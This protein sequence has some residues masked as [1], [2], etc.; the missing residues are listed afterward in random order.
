MVKTV[1]ELAAYAAIT[2]S[3]TTQISETQGTNWARDVVLFGQAL[4]QFDQS[5]IVD[6]SIVNTNDKTAVITKETGTL[7]L[8]LSPSGGE[9]DVADFTELT[10]LDTVSV[11]VANSNHLRGEVAIGKYIS[12][13]SKIDL[14]KQGRY[15]IAE[16]MAQKIDTDLA[17]ATQDTTVDNRVFGDST[18]TDPSGLGA[19]DVM[20]PDLIADGKSEIQANNF[21][22]KWLYVAPQQIKALVKDP[23]FTNAA[24]FGSDSVIARGE[25]TN[26]LGV[27]IVAT[28]N[29]PAFASSASD[30]NQGP[31]YAWGAT[32]H[33]CPMIGVSKRGGQPVAHALVW[34]QQPQV[35]YEYDRRR[36]LHRL[37]FDML[38]NTAMIQP[39]AVCLIKVSDA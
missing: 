24:E 34:K 6:T 19:T 4:R 18:A 9:S 35:D 30:T 28:T 37:Y 20:T 31:T 27:N 3:S 22:P 39:E 33:S 17:A 13:T 25:I 23:Q 10:N 1:E 26:Y 29:T 5:A 15:T 38:Y 11:S 14:I 21:T 7:T 36:V 2:D 8:D 16:Y 12:L 32:G